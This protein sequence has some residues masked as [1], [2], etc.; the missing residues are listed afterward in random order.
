[1]TDLVPDPIEQLRNDLEDALARIRRLEKQL[2]EL[3]DQV[4]EL[5]ASP[6][7]G[8]EPDEPEAEN[9]EQLNL[10][11]YSEGSEE[12]A[13]E[14]RALGAWVRDVLI[15]F[16]GRE[17]SSNRPWCPRW[18]AHPEAVTRLHSLWLAWQELTDPAAG[19]LGLK[20]WE[21]DYLDPTMRELRAPDGPFSAC[22][23]AM[24]GHEAQHRLLD[25][26]QV[27]DVPPL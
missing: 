14:L 1:M 12:Y 8:L 3:H 6:A 10:I 21:R 5:A 4:S 18:W 13:R 15:P 25:P 16:Y 17:P 19:R 26:P 24:H 9:A 20:T 23:Q 11:Y 2:A 7:A 22:S 27:E